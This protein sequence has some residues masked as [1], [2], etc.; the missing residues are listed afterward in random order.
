M[1]STHAV[2]LTD[3]GMRIGMRIYKRYENLKKLLETLG[4]D[5]ASASEDAC[6]MEHAVSDKSFS[7]LM[8]IIEN[9]GV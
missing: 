4:A 3:E 7:A 5:R 8:S 2:H 9:K 6:K 1:D